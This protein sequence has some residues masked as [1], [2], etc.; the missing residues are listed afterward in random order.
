MSPACGSTNQREAEVPVSAPRSHRKDMCVGLGAGDR[1]GV[2]ALITP[3]KINIQQK[4]LM[5][6]FV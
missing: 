4:H 1:P 5:T 6:E 3:L 2:I